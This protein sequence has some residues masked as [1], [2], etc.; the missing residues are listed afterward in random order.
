[1]IENRYAAPSQETTHSKQAHYR[2]A[3]STDQS[4]GRQKKTSNEFYQQIRNFLVECSIHHLTMQNEFFLN[5][6]IADE[7]GDQI[8]LRLGC[9]K[10]LFWGQ[11]GLASAIPLIAAWIP[12]RI[13]STK[14][15]PL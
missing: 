14:S 3:A 4:C 1:M 11:G 8:C 10:G 15:H 12:D 9:C 5:D 7:E 6:A 2:A 13:G